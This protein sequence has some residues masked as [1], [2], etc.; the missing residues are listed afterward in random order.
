M[1]EN[2]SNVVPESQNLSKDAMV[3]TMIATVT[4]II[5]S[6]VRLA[7]SLKLATVDQPELRGWAF[8]KQAKEN[9]GVPN[10]ARVWVK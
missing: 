1:Q 3:L 10:G 2:G 5:R 7:S 8:A 9:A 4:S 6:E